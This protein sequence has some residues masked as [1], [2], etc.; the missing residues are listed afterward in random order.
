MALMPAVNRELETDPAHFTGEDL[1]VEQVTWPEAMEFCDRLN[2]WLST[3]PLSTN[4]RHLRLPTEAEWEYACRAKTTTPFH[5][6][7]TLTTDLA[8]YN[9][10]QPYRQEPVGKFRGMTLPVGIF[11]K[12]NDF[13]LY[14]MHGNVLEWCLPGHGEPPQ[15]DWR[16]VR[17]GSWQ[18]PP[19]DCRSAYRAGFKADTRSNQIGFR[20]VAEVG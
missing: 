10:T 16:V 20:I 3:Q 14:D 2:N 7:Q 5:T 1:P 11:G 9:G 15:D 17:G 13:G 6:G 12:A 8:N 18:S 19:Q 4:L